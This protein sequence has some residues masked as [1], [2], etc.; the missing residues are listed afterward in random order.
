MPIWAQI[1]IGIAAIIVACGIIWTKVLKPVA[2][3]V[4][5]MD[6]A[7]PLLKEMTV[8]FEDAPH[9]FK[10]LEEIVTE[11]RTNSGS[12]LKDVV[13]SLSEAA[14]ENRV[15]VEVLKVNAE[16]IRILSQQDREQIARIVVLLDK[17]IAADK[18]AAE[19]QAVTMK[20]PDNGR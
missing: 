17:T 2:H 3:L 14:K 20:A 4:A 16:A 12:S 15:A 5:L 7:L 1:I 18:A 19:N 13:N 11:F 9:A 6:K 8:Q 10:I